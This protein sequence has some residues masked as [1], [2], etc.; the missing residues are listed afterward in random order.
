MKLLSTLT[1]YLLGAVFTIF[2]LNGFLHFLPMGQVPPH[3]GQFV[4]AMIQS[5]YMMVVFLIELAAGLLLLTGKY[6]PLT[7]VLLGPVIVNIDLFHIFMAPEGLPLAIL[8]T[9]LWM[10]LAYRVRYALSSL[11]N[12]SATPAASLER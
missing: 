9:A 7:V 5:R 3:A 10:V 6:L 8:V 11:W 4:G 1:R 2:G 12:P